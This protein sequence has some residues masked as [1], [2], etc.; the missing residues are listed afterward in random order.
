MIDISFNRVNI[1]RVY[2][3][4]PNQA[5][6]I[7]GLQ[8]AKNKI[9]LIQA[10]SSIVARTKYSEFKGIGGYVKVVLAILIGSG[11]SL[12]SYFFFQNLLALFT[13]LFCSIVVLFI[14]MTPAQQIEVDVSEEGI[15]FDENLLAWDKCHS[16]VMVE[17]DS[18]IEFIIQTTNFDT[19]YYYFYVDEEQESLRSFISSLAQMLPYNEEIEDKN[20]FHKIVR[21]LGLG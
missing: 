8:K 7:S 13:L 12:A 11:L 5:C 19:S 21:F 15:M 6:Q 18:T 16:W 2:H 1:L 9:I 14:I 20:Y 3:I 17:L 10:M 4:Q